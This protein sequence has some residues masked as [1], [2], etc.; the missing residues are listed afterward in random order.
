MARPKPDLARIREEMLDEAERLLDQ[1]GGR[2]LVL[3]DIAASLGMS[4]SNAHRFFPTKQDLVAALAERWFESVEEAVRRAVD[5]HERPA[6]RIEACILA[7]LATKRDRH[8]RDPGLY[9]AYL[10]LARGHGDIIMR[11]AQRLTALLR[12][13]AEGLDTAMPLDDVV[14]LIEDSTTLFRNPYMIAMRR[15][16]ATDERAIAIVRTVLRGTSG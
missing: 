16:A 12:K 10:E 15:D 9:M 6:E 1:S 7:I 14:R 5:R 3:T 2:R 13:A 4:Q 8:D 11:H